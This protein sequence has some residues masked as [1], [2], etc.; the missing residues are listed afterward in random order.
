MRYYVDLVPVTAYSPEECEYPS[1]SQLQKAVPDFDWSGGHSGRVLTDRQACELHKFLKGFKESSELSSKDLSKVRIRNYI[2]RPSYIHPTEEELSRYPTD[3]PRPFI[4]SFIKQSIGIPACRIEK[5]WKKHSDMWLRDHEDLLRT[6]AW[7]AFPIRE[8]IPYYGA[9]CLKLSRQYWGVGENKINAA[10]AKEAADFLTNREL[11]HEAIM[12]WLA[13]S[14]RSHLNWGTGYAVSPL[15]RE[16]VSGLDVLS[17]FIG[18]NVLEQ[19]DMLHDY[20]VRNIEVNT[21]NDYINIDVSYDPEGDEE[22]VL[23]FHI[24][25][26]IDI[27]ANIDSNTCLYINEAQIGPWEEDDVQLFIG[28]Y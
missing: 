9:M 25:G 4:E 23:T 3:N 16:K 7:L 26:G 2:I 20:Y 15:V 17:E 6:A 12:I 27:E 11:K 21:E 14:L 24:S 18:C 1:Q 19:P 22:E 13:E 28:G 5:D 8:E 10:Y